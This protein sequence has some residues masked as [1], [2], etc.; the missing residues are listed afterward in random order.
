VIAITS[1]RQEKVRRLGQ[2]IWPSDVRA[3]T[4]AMAIAALPMQ[5]GS[6]KRLEGENKKG[7]RR[8]PD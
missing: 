6:G 7:A 8:R 5:G 2:L 1:V 4:A 3:P